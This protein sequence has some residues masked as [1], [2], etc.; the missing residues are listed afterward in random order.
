MPCMRRGRALI[1]EHII[2]RLKLLKRPTACFVPLCVGFWEYRAQGSTLIGGMR[3][4]DGLL[5]ML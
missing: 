3:K 2:E 1:F 5:G 4:S